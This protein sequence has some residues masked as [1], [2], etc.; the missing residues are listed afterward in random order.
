MERDE[1]NQLFQDNYKKIFMLAL[2]MLKNEEDAEDATQD[3]FMKAFQNIKKFRHESKF[4]TW[5]YRIALNHI[6]TMQ[7]AQAKNY[8]YD[9]SKVAN[10]QSSITTPE[11]VLSEKE[12][13]DKLEQIIDS[14][15]KRQKEVFLL[16]YYGE[17]PFN[18]I[19]EVCKRSVGTIK[20]S[21]F[22][23]MQKI[24]NGFEKDGLL[25]L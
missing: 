12:L 25:E 15:P 9:L 22:F 20:S 23:A 6:Y 10:S 7:K 14:L 8:H 24:K 16:R 4:S 17:L 18:K 3:I 21:Y 5:L 11:S 1:L 13:F 19:A 2:K